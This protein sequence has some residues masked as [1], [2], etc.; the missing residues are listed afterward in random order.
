MG[1]SVVVIL[2]I[3][4]QNSMEVTLVEDQDPVEALLSNRANPTLRES[5][6]VWCSN[7]GAYDPDILRREDGVKGS[8]ELGVAIVDEDSH[9]ER[10]ILDLPCELARLL[11]HPS[12]RRLCSAAC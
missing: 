3:R 9:W 7:R 1:S 10:A 12:T 11:R 5:V 2:N 4:R 6:C 8:R